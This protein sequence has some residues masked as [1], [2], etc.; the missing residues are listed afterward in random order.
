MPD[1]LP[2]V[3][4]VGGMLVSLGGSALVG[5]RYI[6][7]GGGAAQLKLNQ[8]LISLG[9]AYEDKLRLRDDTIAEM[10][11]EMDGCKERLVAVD[12]GFHQCSHPESSDSEAVY[13][14]VVHDRFGE[15]DSRLKSCSRRYELEDEHAR[16]IFL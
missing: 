4:A 2:P 10:R 13:G 3:I 11:S 6:K 9:Q 15:L 5:R 1:W 7:L 12:G 16:N 14:K 8:T